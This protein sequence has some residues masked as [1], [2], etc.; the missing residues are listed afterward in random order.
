MVE[1]SVC[2]VM[3]FIFRSIY[4]IVAACMEYPLVVFLFSVLLAVALIVNVNAAKIICDLSEIAARSTSRTRA[5]PI[6]PVNSIC[7]LINSV[8]YGVERGELV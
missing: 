8:D 6:R 5:V 1:C 3:N 4:N 2:S 7:S